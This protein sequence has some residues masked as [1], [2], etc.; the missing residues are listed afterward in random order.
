MLKR[1]SLLLI[2]AVIIL[3]YG[4]L[5]EEQSKVITGNSASPLAPSNLTATVISDSQINLSWVDNSP[6]GQA[7]N[8]DGFKI[9]RKTS[10]EADYQ[11]VATVGA[12][13][14]SFADINVQELTNYFYRVIAYND[15]GQ[16]DSSNEVALVSPWTYAT[17]DN[18]GP[19]GLCHAIKV[20]SNNKV[21]I[22]YYDI[23]N[24]DL[25]YATNAS[26]EWVKA[27]IDGVSTDA[28]EYAALAL[29]SNNKAHIS[30][31]DKSN[32][33][34]KYATNASGSWQLSTIDAIDSV[35][36]HTA[37]AI[38]SNG[39]A[40]I[41]YF[42]SVLSSLK[43]ITNKS[44]QWAVTVIDSAGYTGLFTAIAI[45]RNN[46]A[47]I[48]YYDQTAGD[49]RYATNS[50]A[51]VLTDGSADW[52]TFTVD[53]TG[54]VGY[55]PSIAADTGNYAH[56]S[57]YDRT[58]GDLKH[59]ANTSGSWQ[60]TSIDS[61]GDVGK[62][63]GLVIDNANNIH[64]S[65]YDATNRKLKYIRSQGGI[66]AAGQIMTVDA[67][68][69]N[70]S[71]TLSSNQV[72]IAYIDSANNGLKYAN[73][74][75]GLWQVM[76][77]PSSLTA[78]TASASRIDLNW[79]DNSLDELGFKIERRKADETDFVE[80]ASVI[81]DT[82]AF[83]DT[84]LA[85]IT[86]YYYRVRGYGA[87]GNTIYTN[88]AN[89]KTKYNAPSV[90][91]LVCPANAS[92][93]VGLSPILTWQSAT[94]T[95]SYNIQVSATPDFTSLLCDVSGITATSLAITQTLDYYTAYYW[96]VKAINPDE[97]S[98]W[99]T[100]FSFTTIVTVPI[101]SEPAN[102]VIL[103]PIN[104]TLSWT[105]VSGAISYE[106]QI[107][108][109][110]AFNSYSVFTAT[111]TS[112]ALS[113]LAKNTLYYWR[114]RAVRN[115]GPGGWSGV[116]QFTTIMEA[117]ATPAPA[118]P[119]DNAAGIQTTVTLYWNAIST[120][121]SYNLQV[122]PDAGFAT[123][124]IVNLNGISST[125]TQVSALSGE[126]SYWWRVSAA[127]PGGVSA[128][129]GGRKFTT[130]TAIPI[131]L[132]PANNST[133]V[134]INPTLTWQGS[135][136]ASS[137]NIQ[138][139]T[140]INFS[141][142]IVDLSGS[143]SSSYQPS[144]LSNNTAYWWR[145]QAT[146]PGEITD[147]SVV[148]KFTTV[149]ANPSLTAPA[150]NAVGLPINPTLNWS[151]VSGAT[152][153]RLQVTDS[154]FSS[155]VIDE[156]GLTGVF[157]QVSG[158][159][160]WKTYWWRVNASN[161][162][163]TGAWSSPSQFKTIIAAP[164][165]VSPADNLT[166]LS[167]TPNLTWNA[168]DGAAEYQLQVATDS[169][170]GSPLIITIT[171][172]AYQLSAL[173]IATNYWWRLRASNA[174]GTTGWSNVWKFTTQPPLP[175]QPTL[176]S[177]AD[178]AVGISTDPFLKWNASDFSAYYNLQVATDTDFANLV[179]DLNSIGTNKAVSALN[180]STVYYW[181]VRGASN[182]GISAW[183]SIWN[184]TTAL[185][186]PAQPV[187]SAPANGVT[188]LS[189]SITLSW[190]AATNAATYHLRIA[191][192]NMFSN[193]ILNQSNIVGTSFNPPGLAY[194]TNYYWQIQ[195]I[196]NDLMA[197]DWSL[198]RQF[199]TYIGNLSLVSPPDGAITSSANTVLTWAP[200]DYNASYRL[201]FGKDPN[202]AATNMIDQTGIIPTF[203]S[204]TGLVNFTTYYWRVQG[205]GTNIVT[206]W[207]AYHSITKTLS[208]YG[209]GN[210]QCF[211]L[212]T[213]ANA[214]NNLTDCNVS[215]TIDT[216]SLIS[217][218]K[219]QATGND[220]RFTNSSS[221]QELVYLIESSMNTGATKIWVKI[222]SLP[223]GDTVIRMFYGNPSATSS[224]DSSIMNTATGGTITYSGNDAIHTFTT[225]GTFTPNGAWNTAV[226]VVAG[227]G[228]GGM[229]A[230]ST[231]ANGGGGG[232][233]V[234]YNTSYA[235]SGAMAV[236]VGNGGAAIPAGTT[237]IGNN[238]QNSV[239][240]S[241]IAVGGGGGGSYNTGAGQN[242]GSGG[243][244]PYNSGAGSST[245]T[246]GYGNA[247][248]VGI[249]WTG[250]G[251]GGAG[252]VGVA[253][254]GSS[255]G[256]NGGTGFACSI[257][258]S[259][260]YYAGGGGGGDNSGGRAGDGFDGG[261]RGCGATTYY[262]YG[263]WTVEVNATTRGSGTPNAIA[264]TGGGGGGGDSYAAGNGWTTGSG[265][266]GSGIVIIRY[267]RVSVVTPTI[268]VGK[269][270]QIDVTSNLAAAVVSSDRIDLAW[271]DNSFDEVGFKIERSYDGVNFSQIG[272]V[273]ANAVNYSDNTITPTTTYY[274]RVRSYNYGMNGTASNQ[275][276]SNTSAPNPNAP[277]GLTAVF[278][279]ASSIN[280]SWA[281]NSTNETGFK[282]E[283]SFDG[284]LNWTELATR[285]PGT[286][287]YADSGLKQSIIYYYRLRAYNGANYSGYSNE[288]FTK[289]LAIVLTETF[290]TS[291]Y[292]YTAATTANWDTSTGFAKLS[293]TPQQEQ[294]ILSTNSNVSSYY[295]V[296]NRFT[297]NS[298]IQIDKLGAWFSVAS[299]ARWIRIWD[300]SGTLL[301]SVQVTAGGSAG[302][303]WGTLGSPIDLTA[304]AYYRVGWVGIS[305]TDKMLSPGGF[306][307]NTASGIYT[308]VSS[309]TSSSDSF[310][311]NSISYAFCVGVGSAANTYLSSG[312]AQ[313][314][315]L[316]SGSTVVS[317]IM[318]RPTQTTP[319][320][321][322]IS[323]QATP[324]GTNWYTVTPNVLYT[325]P[326]IGTDL[327]WKATLSTTDPTTTPSID[328]L[329]IESDAVP[330][331][332]MTSN[333]TA[334]VV[335]GYQINLNWQDNSSGEDGF[336]IE[337]SIN[338]NLNWV[339]IATVLTNTAIY[340]DNTVAPDTTYYYR[341]RSYNALGNDS[342]SNEEV[343]KTSAPIG[344]SGLI[345]TTVTTV[346][347]IAIS[348]QWQDQSN[349]E[350]G[351]KIERSLDGN[352][353]FP[354]GTIGR[355]IT[356]YADGG[357]K[358][359]NTY[360]HR[361]YAYNALGNSGLSTIIT[362]TVTTSGVWQ[363]FKPITITNAGSAL[364][365]YQVLVTVD[366]SAL[367]SAGKM[368]SLGNDI[369]FTD[370]ASTQEFAYWIE[371]GINTAATKIRVKISSLS[372]GNTVIKM[373]YGNNAAVA[374]SSLSGVF[375]SGIAGY[376]PFDEGAGTA[377]GDFSGNIITGTLVNSPAWVTGMS[378]NGLSFN[379]TNNYVDLGN[380]SALQITGSQTIEMWLNPAVLNDTIRRNPYAKCYGG[381]GTI[382]QEPDG[383][384]NAY[385]GTAGS[386]NT[387]YQG[388]TMPLNIAVSTWVHIAIVRDLTNMKLQ[389]Y[390]NG[391][392]AI[393]TPALYASAVTSSL[394]AY[395][396]KGYV[397]NYSG[398]IDEVRIY[399]RA[400]TAAEIASRYASVAPTVSVGS[401]NLNL[402]V[403]TNLVPAV[404][405]GTQ[406]DLSWQTNATDQTNF[407][408]ERSIN[409]TT[410]WAWFATVLASTY[411]CSDT[412]VDSG[413]IYYYR[414]RSYGNFGYDAWSSLASAQTIAPAS[415]TSLITT[416]VIWNLI[417]LQW[418]D[419]S[420]GEQGFKMER[421]LDGI[422][423]TVTYTISGNTTSYSDTGLDSMTTYYYRVCAYN[424][425][426]VSGWSN[427][428]SD[429]TSIPF[430]GV[431][432]TAASVGRTGAV[433]QWT[434]PYTAVYRIEAWG[435]EGGQS[436]STATPG[437]GARMRGDFSLTQGQVINIVVG[438]Q[439]VQT[440][441]A[442]GNSGN[443]AGGGGGGTFVYNSDGSVLMLAAGGGGAACYGS[444]NGV[445]AV[446]AT[447]GTA[448]PVV[449]NAGGTGGGDGAGGI[450]G[451]RG[452][453]TVQTSPNGI[454]YSGSYGGDGGY[455]GGGG[456][457]S[458]SGGGGGGY[459]GGGGGSN[460]GEG[461]GGGGSYNNGSNQYN[462][463]GVRTG[464]GLVTITLPQAIIY[465][466][467]TNS[468][469]KTGSVQNLTITSTGT[470]SIEVWGARGGNSKYN[471][472]AVPGK[473]ARM[474]GEFNLTDGQ[475]LNIIVGQQGVFVNDSGNT[476][477]G[478]AGGGG[479]SFVYRSGVLL[480]AAG[481][482]GGASHQSCGNPY[483]HGMDAITGTSGT[484]SRGNNLGGTGGG[485]GTGTGAGKGWNTVQTTPTGGTSGSYGGDGGYGGG[486][487]NSGHEGGGGGGYSG[488]GSGLGA[489]SPPPSWSAGGGGG[490]YNSGANQSNSNGVNSAQGFLIII[491]IY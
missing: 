341:V 204:I 221:T 425:V 139:A 192:D 371:S 84:G 168:V 431:V 474:K 491:K 220:I 34:L 395:I 58:N 93:A 488:G 344:P 146:R 61:V 112:Y 33:H 201:Q 213:M 490:S 409:N 432:Y 443:G 397:N 451:G 160:N 367:I 263:V 94:N 381:E 269:H 182:D 370:S 44:G 15:I 200:G 124:L 297:P 174:D 64:I 121:V 266:G 158:L 132:L 310:P 447:S 196:S 294:L 328:T 17:I 473:G 87:T 243:G 233:G 63:S 352:T 463:G 283:R 164:T 237:A 298:N 422:N 320:N 240:G 161:S 199:T 289:N 103:Q 1:I 468:T 396:G 65:Y 429:T 469:G 194:A 470:Y 150:D 376:W 387:P 326:V 23:Y 355:N 249:A 372:T 389:W 14:T 135:A 412:P 445:D 145:V 466:L 385:Y 99:S 120:A 206:P 13:I 369:R 472:T 250:G 244:A 70:N 81:T 125:S 324:D 450:A 2:G 400:L 226:L 482:G 216:A 235:V 481:G 5:C 75:K 414:I 442:S 279:G 382:T 262:A 276:S 464:N 315:K 89:A 331:I 169:G 305:D 406:I 311:T 360:Y 74:T 455:G 378:G 306:P 107:S 440:T 115:S 49:L 363:Y 460:N 457:N 408:I 231:N 205:I 300:D 113:G 22:V 144:Q 436:L 334:T 415:P 374:A 227:G 314:I 37:I 467:G 114:V 453:N 323:Y 134:S 386:N 232:G 54:D 391:V 292:K 51:A 181:R 242:G 350:D 475:V 282:I 25:K 117:P 38:D 322:T 215:V 76:Y 234:I 438:Q 287:S 383:T 197:G 247:G 478:G 327:R 92:D 357:L 321:T 20:D 156:S 476:S 228:S 39:K 375:G 71:I 273:A 454:A 217:N 393:E 356:F 377:A 449:F 53:S 126:T 118:S 340:S 108:A 426:D 270:N 6:V 275:E 24:G 57:Y 304:G 313:S 102:N 257:S 140:D 202:F 73:N 286:T 462:L 209:G 419:N 236:T 203:Y 212:I 354:A 98:A 219:M 358:L 104:P 224:S 259:T 420:S 338:D 353:W 365:N 72:H 229:Y 359:S 267:V 191:T 175:A 309:W 198:C 260:K 3:S 172:T 4:G 165:L 123:N 80:I 162:G 364:T 147:W 211:K 167:L 268:S 330:T 348:L 36:F 448:S 349:N 163:G 368:N 131:L 101:L 485:D 173:N 176:L 193:I 178:T 421:S 28:G 69:K 317:N 302:W 290:S 79:Q 441:G 301:G 318:L 59:A 50:L 319:A 487:A 439:G 136:G 142:L 86:S 18:Q 42:D 153:Y 471:A 130:M 208:N 223:T 258:G 148:F 399:N 225:S 251:G 29:D 458:Q 342:W 91:V 10:Q 271:Q 380:P 456:N 122:A 316:N 256:G 272:T 19:F 427:P 157:R 489:G 339:Q 312:V 384:I 390:K 12:D 281:D 186:I 459:S 95:I 392:L 398:I 218:G 9:E 119:A 110:S 430:P 97:T 401:E 96:R 187:L 433:Q 109:D 452:W 47:H 411:N 335:S 437:K 261:G 285:T 351:F 88:E 180:N 190:D 253:G 291:T 366:T 11:Q 303:Y 21:H 210:W 238:G 278:V 404:M 171:A 185:A 410:S 329:V 128:W 296:A 346:N 418:A 413:N 116:R 222:P 31:Y 106:L 252:S 239:F 43:Y 277:S 265:A 77:P 284:G 151:A 394:T 67:G 129:S 333:L 405:S 248:G 274:Y 45:D 155:P 60:H 361:V 8:E 78:T 90:P 295:V 347:P 444:Y 403:A 402:I 27:V 407:V 143:V 345:T 288:A 166:W 484:A 137:Y 435:A 55:Y 416:T 46:K 434:V 325:F 85:S 152:S 154:D 307:Y 241:L 127:N 179:S 41:S 423:W 40:H 48:G 177:P 479:G 446:T 264:N 461:G 332:N 141:A 184:F 83:S 195:A 388:F 254:S 32:A 362:P 138:L 245:Q 428:I 7:N 207:T 56:I 111:A 336:K 82:I 465:T 62:C 337:R 230:S 159:A 30:Y 373:F 66:F 486:G 293:P 424:G 183:S 105:G 68:G 149:L 16:S 214:G 480:I 35:G 308:V 379:G 477:N 170:F 26:C 255:P 189:L 417:S 280:L 100:V 188:G 483:Y 343:T 133:G 52:R 299:V 246:G